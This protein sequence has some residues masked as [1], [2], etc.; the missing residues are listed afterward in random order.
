MSALF[1]CGTDLMVSELNAL[2]SLIV[3][4]LWSLLIV[5]HI[6]GIAIY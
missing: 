3:H 4:V 1:L 6:L 5:V 2:I